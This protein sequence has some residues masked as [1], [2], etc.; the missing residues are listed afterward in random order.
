MPPCHRPYH[1]VATA[2]ITASSGDAT[3]IPRI[4]AVRDRLRLTRGM[5]RRATREREL[6][7]KGKGS[8]GKKKRQRGGGRDRDELTRRGGTT[9]REKERAR[10]SADAADSTTGGGGLTAPLHIHPRYIDLSRPPPSSRLTSLLATLLSGTRA[11]QKRS[12][13][14]VPGAAALVSAIRRGWGIGEGSGGAGAGGG[15]DGHGGGED[16]RGGGGDGGGGAE[17]T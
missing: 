7:K 12:V 15:G 1:T 3:T 8:E 16:G 6:W 10:L 5:T 11:H 17:L 9:E 14:S 4:D 2:V 13:E